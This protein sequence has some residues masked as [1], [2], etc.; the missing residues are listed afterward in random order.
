MCVSPS[1]GAFDQ[2]VIA[3][4]ETLLLPGGLVLPSDVNGLYLR[5]PRSR[6][7]NGGVPH[8]ITYSRPNYTRAS[9]EYNT[10]TYAMNIKI[11]GITYGPPCELTVNHYGDLTIGGVPLA[12]FR[13]RLAKG[14]KR[15]TKV[16]TCLVKP[17]VGE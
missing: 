5:S 17:V 2:I 13:M 1:V 6:A 8:M 9:V 14:S 12:G 10:D 4:I 3:K 11:W 15:A 7:S 16:F